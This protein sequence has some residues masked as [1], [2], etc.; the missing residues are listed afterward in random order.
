M[1]Y[2]SEHPPFIERIRTMPCDQIAAEIAV[3]LVGLKPIVDLR[4]L[5]NGHEVA[6]AP[7]NTLNERRVCRSIT[8]MPLNVL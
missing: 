1:E 6:H 3:V 2:P 8:Q 7:F 4:R 5:L